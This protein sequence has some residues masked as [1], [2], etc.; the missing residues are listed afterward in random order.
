MISGIVQGVTEFLPISSSGH[1]VILHR[2]MGMN[3]PQMLFD[4]FLHVGTILA[5]GVVFWKEII[6]AFTTK[7]IIGFF[8]IV[9]SIVTVSFVLIFDKNIEA[10]FGNARIVGA[11]LMLTGAWI[12]L[13][14]LV[15]FGTEGLSFIKVVLIGLAQGIAAFPGISRSGATISTGLFLGLGP[16][17]AATFSFLLSIPAVFGALLFK[18]KDTAINSAVFNGTYIVGLVVSFIVG[19]MSLKLLLKILQKNKFHFFGIYCIII[20]L[21]TILFLR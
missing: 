4:I 6:E 18:L 21:L 9:A 16:K 7:K 19:I 5:I 11:M 2:L 17:T 8:I 20:G 1:L 12:I 15:R 13:G 14:N 3:E 10:A